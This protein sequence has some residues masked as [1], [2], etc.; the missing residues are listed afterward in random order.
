MPR[1]L[2]RREFLAQGGAAAG[3]LAIGPLVTHP[4]RVGSR[5][6]VVP[7]GGGTQLRVRLD[8]FAFGLEDGGATT[9]A[10]V[11]GRSGPGVL[12]PAIDGPEPVDPL[13][14]LGAY[15]AAGFVVGPQAGVEFPSSFWTGNRL[16][17]ASGGAVVS[18]VAVAGVRRS[19]QGWALSLLTDL[20]AAGPA[21]LDI[22]ALPGGGVRLDLHPPEALAAAAS[23]FTLVSPPD[24]GL[25]GLGARK[26]AFNQR[27]LMR[28]VW[29]EQENVDA[30]PFAPVSDPVFGS[31]YTF[32]NG[33][34][35]AYY[36]QA[37][38]FG[39]RG[40]AAWVGQAALSRLDLAASRSDVV[41]W[42]VA[43]PR[44]T[45]FLAG[46]GL[47][48]A[49][50]AYTALAGRAPAPPSYVY[51]PWMDV[52][53][54]QGE[55]DAAPNGAGF[56]GGAA[57]RARVEQ[58]VARSAALDIPLGVVGVEGWQA[59][60]DM[61]ELAASVRGAGLHLAAYWNPFVSPSNPVYAVASSQGYLV[62]GADGRPYP[63]VNNRGNTS[64]VIDFTNPAAAAWWATQLQRSSSLGFEAFMHD[65]GEFVTQAMVFA[66]G[67]PPELVHNAYP[68]LY[69][70]AARRAVDGFAAAHPGFDPFFYV[71]SGYSALGSGH[72]VTAFTPGVFPGDETTDWSVASGLASVVPAMLNLAMGGAF[73]FTTD[74][75]G[76][77]DLTTPRTTA[78]LFTRWSQLAALTAVSRIHNSTENGSVYPWD[79]D[80]TTLDTYRRYAKAK[81]RL[82]PVVDAW[83]RLASSTGAI[84][85]VR[86]IVLAD[87][88][89]AAASVDDQWLLGDDLLVA[90]V[91]AQGARSRGV[92]LPAGPRWEL[93]TVADD[94][95]LAPS[96]QVHDGGVTIEAPAPLTDI[97]IFRRLSG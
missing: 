57:V 67:Q 52:I 31:T 2:S 76:Y 90:P 22:D 21:R 12:G 53:N 48:A 47:G 41:R 81:V 80:D 45:L 42:G 32:P 39:G 25:Y 83:S 54:Q 78:E 23:V 9:V 86:P 28:N 44:L 62:R 5:D 71:R 94:G 72:G 79:F 55:G 4:S 77:L 17:G 37:L 36:V 33:A 20:P 50:S 95:H 74:V 11:S 75:G 46:G 29:A 51:L 66:N 63:L 73:T 56:S 65:Y 91:L 38:L 70:Q 40:W 15:P 14:S 34:Q 87:P 92:Y 89:P 10:S 35:G 84:G 13:G 59:V 82:A 43:S 60:P 6:L 97:P 7:A 88:S 3:A 69:H 64:Y 49:S 1:R 19:G 96:G 8:P 30:G 93:L 16:F 61:A 24:E 58:V 85:P 68:V 18:V 26:D 27:G